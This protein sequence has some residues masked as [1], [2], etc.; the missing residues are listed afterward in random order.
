MSST[1]PGHGQSGTVTSGR[2][3]AALVEWRLTS[4]TAH[5]L[6]AIDPNEA[7]PSMGV[8]ADQIYCNA[9]NLTFIA[10]QLET[11][12]YV[13]RMKDPDEKRSNVLRLTSA[14]EHAR[15]A[16]VQATLAVTPFA[17]CDDDDLRD[18]ALL[19]TRVNARL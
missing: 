5:A 4:Q 8:M 10:K 3:E 14:G 1:S 7:P 13:S 16:V 18:L 19:F 2:I 15:A 9:P 11:R 17:D 12:G 6:L